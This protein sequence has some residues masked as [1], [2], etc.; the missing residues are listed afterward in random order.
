LCE[1]KGEAHHWNLRG[2]TKE[3]VDAAWSYPRPTK[4]FA[5]LRDCVAFYPARV[6]ACYV[7]DERVKAQEG[8][9]YGGWITSNVRGPFKGGP[10]TSGW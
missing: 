1:W 3:S 5:A 6:D 10:G 4:P 8:D 2:G 7:G 9:F